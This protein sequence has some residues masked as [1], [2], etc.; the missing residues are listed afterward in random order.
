MRASM[1]MTSERMGKINYVDAVFVSDRSIDLQTK[2]EEVRERYAGQF[3]SI[4]NRKQTK[5]PGDVH[6]TAIR[7]AQE[8]QGLTGAHSCKEQEFVAGL[9]LR[10]RQQLRVDHS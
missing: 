8:A 1:I 10:T 5:R 3:N 7:P 9:R 4:S 2:S 6:A